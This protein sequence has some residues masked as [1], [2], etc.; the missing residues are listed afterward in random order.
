M[1]PNTVRE[2]RCQSWRAFCSQVR[3]NRFMGARLF[4]GHRDPAWKLSSIWERWLARSKGNDPQRNVRQFFADGAFESMR[5]SYLTRFKTLSAGIP[6]LRSGDLSENDWWAI[7]RHHGLT[8]PILDW[9]LSPYVA[10]FFAFFDYGEWLNP[11]F[12]KGVNEGGIAY[13]VGT[14]VVW[15]LVITSET[16]VADEFELFSSRA[17]FA[18]RQRA[19]QGVFTRLTHDVYVDV[20]AYLK[21]RGLAHL[22]ARYEIPGSEMGT[23]LCDLNLMN[24]SPS[25]MFPDLDGAAAMANLGNVLELLGSKDDT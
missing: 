1:T 25:T 11:G 10:S 22:L 3:P 20:E 6:G 14:V 7:G 12:S 23:A 19:Q 18:E 16:V 24:I 13:G 5:D 15:E 21:S 4:R 9:T 17:D 2:Y 8:T